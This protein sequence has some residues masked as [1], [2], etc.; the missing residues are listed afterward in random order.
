MG[1]TKPAVLDV[2]EPTFPT[3]RPRKAAAL[4]DKFHLSSRGITF[5]TNTYLPEWMEVGVE[6]RIPQSGVREDEEI[7]CRGVIVQCTRREA[8]KGFEVALLF[9]DLPKK[10]HSYLTGAPAP[11]QLISISVTR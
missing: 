11:R 6:M 5:A 2:F 10:A 3:S 9:L 1:A 7:G 8:G 4:K